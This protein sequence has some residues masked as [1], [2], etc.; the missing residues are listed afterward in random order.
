MLKTFANLF[1]IKYYFQK[2]PRKK[3]NF[4]S[5]QWKEIVEKKGREKVRTQLFISYS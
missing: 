4:P 2:N 5:Y 3:A 1:M